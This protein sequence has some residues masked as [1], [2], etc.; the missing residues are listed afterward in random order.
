MDIHGENTG[1]PHKIDGL[2]NTAIKLYEF[3]D[4]KNLKPKK[5]KT[6]FEEFSENLKV[7][8]PEGLCSYDVKPYFTTILK[9]LED[10][11]QILYRSKRQV[12]LTT[13]AAAYAIY[14]AMERNK[15][16]LIVDSVHHRKDVHR[17]ILQIMIENYKNGR[18]LEY[19]RMNSDFVSFNNNSVIGFSNK[20]VQGQQKIDLVIV[21]N[22]DYIK[23]LETINSIKEYDGKLLMLSTVEADQ[24]TINV[25]AADSPKIH[26]INDI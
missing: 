7:I 2:L 5:E 15:N 13:F 10:H 1:N 26:V 14:T 23:K 24:D 6:S 4:G 18:F 25:I 11:N 20:I 21:D 8:R 12:G 3:V 22:F 16:I 9:N 17:R 19:N